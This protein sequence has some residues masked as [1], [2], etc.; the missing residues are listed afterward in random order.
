MPETNF[1]FPRAIIFDLDG[2]LLDT[3]EDLA[4]SGNAVVAKRGLPTH[5]KEDYKVFIGDGMENLVQR[6]FPEGQRPASEEELAAILEEYKSE[7]EKHWNETTRAFDGIPELLDR[8]VE[9]G[10]KLGVLS[11]KAHEFTVKCVEEFLPDWKWDVIFGQRDGVPQKP[12]PDAAIEAAAVMDVSPD[13]CWFVGDSDVDVQTGVNAGMTTIGVTWGFRTAE[14]LRAN[15]ATRVV[16]RP[17]E[18]IPAQP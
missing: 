10:I 18:I 15:G 17:D 6:I 13:E 5:S 3:L 14:E 9:Q 7:Y 16:D 12:A 8:A 1:D 11:N 2:T 4:N